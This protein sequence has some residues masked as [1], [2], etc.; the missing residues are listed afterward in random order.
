M[1]PVL[2]RFLRRQLALLIRHPH[3][4]RPVLIDGRRVISIIYHLVI[5]VREVVAIRLP[6]SPGPPRTTRIL[7]WNFRFRFLSWLESSAAVSASF[8]PTVPTPM[9]ASGLVL[10]GSD[11]ALARDVIC[12][13]SEGSGRG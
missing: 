9:D 6:R 4:I 1:P 8:R 13:S 5:V 7:V 12:V 3:E 11:E 2:F 10:A